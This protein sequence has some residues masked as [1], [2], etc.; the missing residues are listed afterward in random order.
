MDVVNE[1]VYPYVKLQFFLGG[2]EEEQF[3][4]F[5][6]F[7]LVEMGEEFVFEVSGG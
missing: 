7:S 5:F 1:E 2:E 4:E 3:K 6:P